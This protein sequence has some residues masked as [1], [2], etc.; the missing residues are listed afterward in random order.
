M[1][2]D[3]L[4]GLQAFEDLTDIAVPL[5]KLDR[6]EPGAVVIHDEHRPIVTPAKEA[7]HW[8]RAPSRRRQMTI[9]TSTR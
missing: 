5:A 1:Q 7:P 6:P 3:D 9:R 8:N 4:T 2:N